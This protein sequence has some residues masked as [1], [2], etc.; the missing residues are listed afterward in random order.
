M[1]AALLCRAAL[2]VRTGLQSVGCT[3]HMPPWMRS[4]NT[5]RRRFWSTWELRR[6]FDYSQWLPDGYPLFNKSTQ[7]LWLILAML[8]DTND[9]ARQSRNLSL[10]EKARR[11]Y[12]SLTNSLRRLMWRRWHERCHS[13]LHEEME[14]LCSGSSLWLPCQGIS[15]VCEK[16][17][18]LPLVWQKW[19]AWSVT[20]KND[21]PREQ[22]CCRRMQISC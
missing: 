1:L 11:R 12:N 4:C 20:S 2:Q 5:E 16:P 17:Y 18:Y 3:C 15:D 6:P 7:Q 19:T 21:L 14:C 10:S 9:R 22:L 13:L 8:A